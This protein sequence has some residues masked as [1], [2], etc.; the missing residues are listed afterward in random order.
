MTIW[1]KLKV[2][3]PY[4]KISNVGTKYQTIDGKKTLVNPEGHEA[5]SIRKGRFVSIPDEWKDLEKVKER[6]DP[7]IFEFF[8]TL[9][10]ARKAC[11][12]EKKLLGMLPFKRMEE[13]QKRVQEK[14]AK[15]RY[16]QK[17]PTMDDVIREAKKIGVDI[18]I[19]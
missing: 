19:K 10:K 8:K 4:D 5:F 7:A 15:S 3:A 14:V 17:R 9:S 13:R 12:K 1:V 18:P 2:F 16:G 11:D 6:F